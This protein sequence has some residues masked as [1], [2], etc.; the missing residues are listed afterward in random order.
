VRQMFAKG[1]APRR[2]E[3]CARCAPASSGSR[4]NEGERNGTEQI[5]IRVPNEPGQLA[6]VAEAL[7]EQGIDVKA[8]SI[9]CDAGDGFVGDC[10]QQSSEGD[11]GA[12]A[13]GLGGE[14]NADHRRLRAR[15]PGGLKAV[16]KPLREAR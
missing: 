12:C 10:R 14:R 3:P 1:T 11:A 2:A 5:L 7:S 6:K 4:P 15:S 8:V 16:I 9:G 13:P